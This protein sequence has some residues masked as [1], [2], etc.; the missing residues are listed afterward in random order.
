[1]KT[2]SL[3]LA[4]SLKS[5]TSRTVLAWTIER[6]DGVRFAFTSGDVQFTYQG[7][8][9]EPT[10]GFSGMAAASKNNLAVDNISALG[11]L[12]SQITE[13]DLKTGK[14]DNAKIRMFWIDPFHPEYG[15]APLRSGRIGEIKFPQNLQFEAEM[16]S[17]QQPLQQ[18]FGRVYTLECPYTFGDA[19]CRYQLIPV[20]WSSGLTV[21]AQLPQDAGTGFIVSPSVYN[22]F[23]YMATGGGTTLNTVSDANTLLAMS[24]ADIQKQA[25]L[26]AAQFGGFV[27]AWVFSIRAKQL[28]AYGAAGVGGYAQT[29][30]LDL[31]TGTTGATEP[32]WPTV[33]GGTVV[34]NDVTW[35]AIRARVAQGTV[36]QAV[37]RVT[38]F[39]ANNPYPALY[40][41][42]GYIKWLTGRNAGYKVEIRDFQTVPFPGFQLLEQCP[43]RIEIGDTYEATQGC[44]KTRL[45]CN[46][47]AK[48]LWNYGGFPDM[49]T[50]DKAL[51]TPNVKQGTTHQD[52]G[53][54]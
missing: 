10:N 12:T 51:S 21:T 7:D 8:T 36:T 3:E 5:R 40:F 46:A 16:R 34:D 35:T 25:E 53:K 9:F 44:P 52:S 41:Q 13:Q 28:A 20:P 29:P 2:V 30:A 18:P 27:W 19:D 43:Y 23:W 26:M 6:E 32:V 14:F 50:E 33:E 31:Q 24:D 49:P 22:G 38:F 17:L 47:T 15:I 45:F 11:M 54:G 48:N 4:N 42:Y 37:D 1:M 39:D